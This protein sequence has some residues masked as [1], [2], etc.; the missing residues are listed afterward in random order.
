MVNGAAESSSKNSGA[1]V[2]VSTNKIHQPQPETQ[3]QKYSVIQ[4]LALKIATV[5]SEAGSN[6]C[7]SKMN[8]LKK[9]LQHWESG[10]SVCV[11]GKEVTANDEFIEEFE[12]E[13]ST[14]DPPEETASCGDGS[15]ISLENEADAAGDSD[16]GL[17]GPVLETREIMESPFH[18]QEIVVDETGNSDEEPIDDDVYN[19][20]SC[21]GR[22]ES[23]KQF[24]FVIIKLPPKMRKRGHPKGL[25]NTVIG[26]SRRKAKV[27]YG[28]SI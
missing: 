21:T 4:F 20:A 7:N 6:E 25:A 11:I 16:D 8:V 1:S 27:T 24:P 15:D 23:R 18:V 26:L 13:D 10:M 19:Q 28:C 9:V 14:D 5:V 17:N 22:R 2:V 3:H 12:C